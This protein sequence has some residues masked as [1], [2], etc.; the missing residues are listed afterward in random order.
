MSRAA[1]EFVEELY[2]K[3]YPEM[4]KRIDAAVAPLLEFVQHKGDCPQSFAPSSDTEFTPAIALGP[5]TC[6]L[7]ALLAKWRTDAD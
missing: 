6:D 3:P 4:E 7:D 5:C 1:R 2:L